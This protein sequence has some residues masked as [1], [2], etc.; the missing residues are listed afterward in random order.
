MSLTINIETYKQLCLFYFSHI[1]QDPFISFMVLLFL[2][3]LRDQLYDNRKLDLLYSPIS[4]PAFIGLTI[5]DQTIH[6][7]NS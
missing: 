2:L 7:F 1:V 3:M 6:S 4:I 5:S